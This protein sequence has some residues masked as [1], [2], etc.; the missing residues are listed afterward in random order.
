MAA[1]NALR[2][3]VAAAR[4]APSSDAAPSLTEQL[5]AHCQT[6]CA[7]LHGHHTSEDSAFFPY[8][9]QVNPDLGPALER[10]RREHLVVDR[11]L[12]DL[13]ASVGADDAGRVREELDRL[14]TELE[15]HFAYEEE[16]IVP[17]LN[18]L[19]GPVPWDPQD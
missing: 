10:L 9:A 17:A 16:Q 4:A 15:T 14:A 11:I 3:F 5:R 2:G 1:H 18:A 19:T 7:Y 8:L 6:V 13:D 12:R